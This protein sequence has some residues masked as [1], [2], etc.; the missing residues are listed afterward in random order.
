MSSR[1]YG[2]VAQFDT[3]QQIWHACEKIRDAQFQKW[4]AHTPYPVHGLEFAMGMKRSRLPFFVAFM[5][6]TGASLAFWLQAWISTEAYRLVIAGKPYLSW[7]AFVPVTFEAMVL[8]SAGSTVLGMLFLNRLP[9]WHNPFLKSPAFTRSTD[10]K[11]VV[12]IEAVDPKFNADETPK[13]L[14]SLGASHV[15]LVEE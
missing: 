13:F 4:D 10:D 12:T 1:V 15:E 14:E 7:Q 8:F 11:F 3:A 9:R 2:V 5:G 6:I